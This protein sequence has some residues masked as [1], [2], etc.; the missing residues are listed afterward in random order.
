MPISLSFYTRDRLYGRYQNCCLYC[1]MEHMGK[2]ITL[3]TGNSTFPAY[4]A[5]PT[6]DIKGGIIVIHEI[7]GLADHIKSICDRFANEGYVALGPDL[8]SETGIEEHVTPGLA[9]ALFDPDPEKRVAIQPQLRGI[10]AP[11]HAPEF[12]GTAKTKLE[13]CFRYMTQETVA[14]DKVA[15]TGFCFGGTYSFQLAIS[16]PKLKAAI[17]FYGH[18]DFS[19]EELGNIQCPVLAFYGEDDSRLIS[20]LP[21]LDSIMK[22]AGVTFEYVVYPHCGHAFFNDTN[23]FTYNPEAA[24]DAWQRTLK[25]LE[26]NLSV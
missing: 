5:E 16:E 1:M 13:E 22:K 2:G 4:L 23:K 6:G 25:F 20:A 7:W 8:L 15:V 9:E 21:D 3:S 10:M 18:S 11:I 12:A 26:A 17:P 19:A 14:K 24:A